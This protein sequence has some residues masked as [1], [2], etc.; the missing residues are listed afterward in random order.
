MPPRTRKTAKETADGQFVK[1]GDVI[2]LEAKEGELPGNGIAVLPD[3]SAV[4]IRQRYQIQHEGLHVID[5]VEYLAELP[6][7]SDK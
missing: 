3:G 6:D 7:K 1:V 4:T 2:E 5:G